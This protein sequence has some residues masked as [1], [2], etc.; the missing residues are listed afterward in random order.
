M[1]LKGSQFR[2][3]LFFVTPVLAAP[4]PPHAVRHGMPGDLLAVPVNT[5][6]GRENPPCGFHAPAPQH[7]FTL[8]RFPGSP[9]VFSVPPLR[10]LR[11]RQRIRVFYSSKGSAQSLPLWRSELRSGFCSTFST[12]LSHSIIIPLPDEPLEYNWPDPSLQIRSLTPQLYLTVSVL[13]W[14]IPPPSLWFCPMGVF[15]RRPLSPG[16]ILFWLVSDETAPSEAC[17]G[18]CETAFFS[19]ASTADN[20]N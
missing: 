20:L 10:S 17:I 4:A 3:P 12:S 18:L 5:S 1:T 9:S 19:I 8:P 15:K 11:K 14:P 16:R 7:F 2:L 6:S 13:C